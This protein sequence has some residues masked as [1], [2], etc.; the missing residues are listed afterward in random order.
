MAASLRRLQPR[1]VLEGLRPGHERALAL[2]L[3]DQPAWL[4]RLAHSVA[5]VFAQALMQR[6]RVVAAQL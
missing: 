3:D 2:H 4:Q 6:Q 5:Q 1:Q